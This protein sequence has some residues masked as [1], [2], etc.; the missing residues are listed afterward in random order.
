MT[1]GKRNEECG[2][3]FYYAPTVFAD[4]DNNMTLVL[5]YPL[6]ALRKKMK[7]ANEY[8]NTNLRCVNV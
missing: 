6:F 1:G 4:I 2:S 8:N 3:G 7:K 5:S